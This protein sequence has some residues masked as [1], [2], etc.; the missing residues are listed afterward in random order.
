MMP[1][2]SKKSGLHTF[3]V[4]L[5]R[6]SSVT[7]DGVEIKGVRNVQVSQS[8]AGVPVVVIE[9]LAGRV[10]GIPEK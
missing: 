5:G 6:K 8:V 7:I 3:G 10:T 1:E 2:E 4:E 9:I